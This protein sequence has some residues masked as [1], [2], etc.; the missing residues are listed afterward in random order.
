[1]RPSLPVLATAIALAAP[2][3]AQASV[4]NP[5]PKVAEGAKLTVTDKTG[6]TGKHAVVRYYLSADKKHDLGDLR[7]IGHRSAKRAK[8]TARL[9]VPYTAPA[10]RLFLLA[11][12]NGGKSC[13]ASSKSTQVTVAPKD[14]SI[15]RTLND[16]ARLSEEDEDFLAQIGFTDRS[17]PVRAKGGT[18]SL[19]IALAKAQAKLNKAGGKKGIKAFKKSSAAKSPEAAED[20]ANRA[21][22]AG[23]PGGALQALLAAHRMQPREPAHLVNAASVMAS[24]GMPREAL[25]LLDA[26]DDLEPRRS[27]PLGINVQAIALNAK[28]YALIQLGRYDDALPYLRAAVALDPYFSEARTNLGVAL[29]CKKDKQGIRFARAGQYRFLGDAVIGDRGDPFKPPSDQIERLDLSGGQQAQIPQFKLPHDVDEAS[30][31]T[32]AYLA[33]QQEFFARSVKRHSRINDLIAQRTPLNNLSERRYQDLSFAI[34]L[35]DRRPDIAAVKQRLLDRQ[36]EIGQWEDRTFQGFVPGTD[37]PRWQ[38]ESHDACRDAPDEEKC[39]HD[40]YFGKCRGPIASAHGHWLSLMNAQLTDFAQL[41]NLYYP[42]ATGIA[43]NISDANRQEVESLQ[44]DDF[45][46]GQF[47]TWIPTYAASWGNLVRLTQCWEDPSAPQPPGT[48]EVQTPHSPPCSDFLR[49]VKLAWKIGRDADLGI[50]FDISIEVNCEKVSVEASGKVAGGD[51]G[52]IGA[53]GEVSYAPGTGKVS[54]FGGP[55]AGGKIPGTSIGGSIKDGIYVTVSEEGVEDVGFRVS[56]SVQV[57]LDSFS[58]KGG[59][60]LDFSFAPVFGVER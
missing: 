54:I 44:I 12:A 3:A 48:T 20:A 25:A 39:F 29:L 30:L 9:R 24:T 51:Y 23:E 40:T 13:S 38:Q 15:P 7:L 59:K 46:D 4:S 34:V 37:Y 2:A 18:P 57:G 53:F 19:Q 1:M 55:K 43:G 50:P 52:W 32:P 6:N 35:V 41:Q 49:G 56:P 26:A 36:T 14:R 31:E 60:S 21:M 58:V 27:T 47:N 5:P 10:G 17:C 8:G 33:G 11:C 42:I 45:V 22:I 16:Q 28:G